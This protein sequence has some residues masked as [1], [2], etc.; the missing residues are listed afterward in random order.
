MN[1]SRQVSVVTEDVPYAIVKIQLAGGQVIPVTM[2]PLRASQLLKDFLTG[3]LHLDQKTV[4]GEADILGPWGVK[5]DAIIAMQ[6]FDSE[7]IKKQQQLQQQ[8]QQQVG[9]GTQAPGQ[10]RRPG[11]GM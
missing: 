3:R 1:P 5:V 11:S 2:D 4:I 8:Q 10:L 6:V 7:E 9:W